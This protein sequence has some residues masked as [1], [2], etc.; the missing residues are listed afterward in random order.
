MGHPVQGAHRFP[1]FGAHITHNGGA[2][3][4]ANL[5]YLGISRNRTPHQQRFG[6]I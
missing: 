4:L 3:W 5:F 2:V 6:A 1:W